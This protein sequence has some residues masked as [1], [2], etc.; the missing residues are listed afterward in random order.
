MKGFALAAIVAACVLGVWGCS[1]EQY[2]T[3]RRGAPKDSLA[4][5][6]KHDIVALTKA[7]IG[8]E[9]IIKMINTTGSTFQLRTP[10]VIALADSGVVDTVIHAMLQADVSSEKGDRTRVVH[11]VP[12]DYYWWYGAPYYDPWW[13]YGRPG[14]YYGF[15]AYGGFHGWRRR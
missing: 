14:P 13:Y 11:Y 1:S 5:M 12:S 8:P 3:H 10:D 7:G 9:V 6:T 15:R 2:T 4:T